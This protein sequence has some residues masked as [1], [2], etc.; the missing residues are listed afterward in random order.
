[1]KTNKTLLSTAVAFGLLSSANLANAAGFQLA[2]YSAT[3]LGRAYA[4]EAAMADNASAQ[5]RNP[6]M[7]TYLEG[8]QVSV[9]AIYVNPNIDIDGNVNFA[10]K[11]ISAS[12]D[13][14][15]HDAIIPNFYLSHQYNEKIAIGFALGTNYGMET[16]LGKDF[17]ASHFGNEAS[18]ISKEANLNLAYQ[19]NEQFSIGGGVRYIIAEGS[20][21]ATAP[22][23]NIL[24]L[25]QG[26]TLKYMEGDDTTW[27]WQV[28]SAWQINENH[29]VGFTYKS[30][31]ELK[32]EGH[33]EGVGFG[34]NPK[35]RDNGY[36]YLTL[37]ATAEL[38]SFHQLTEKL[39]MHASF[40]WTDW[41]S[42]EKLE[43]HMETAGTQMVKEEHW[44]DNYRFA[45][46]A[47][48]QLQPKLA[49]RTGIAY[50]TS[51]VS[52]KNRTITIPETDRTWLSVGATYDWTQNFTLDAGFT[53]IIAK[54][55][56]IKE[57]R[58]YSSDEAAQA[59]GGQFVGETTGNVW[60]IGV[61]ANY[62]F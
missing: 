20:F 22:E 11:N 26:T 4:G 5:W 3:G 55:A 33:A 29:R 45:V 1:M 34:I 30:E 52:D 37:P 7:L 59:V 9:G 39:A 25:P 18:V 57:S 61:Q 54:D 49:L 35:S 16:D 14:F 24:N 2:E 48:Y 51:A 23:T 41:S 46:G 8:T 31:V 56:P 42:F 12:S 53:Y 17:A 38:A 27:G 44:E 47:T 21:G 19:L 6:A 28:G 36:M 43:A 10:G 58:G 50:D 40:N 62:R 32:L 13:D 15:A 60:L